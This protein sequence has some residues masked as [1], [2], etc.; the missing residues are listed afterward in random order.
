MPELLFYLILK[1]EFQINTTLERIA[2][3]GKILF[4]FCYCIINSKGI[5]ISICEVFTPD[6]D[7]HLTEINIT[8]RT[9]RKSTRLNSS[10]RSLSRMPSSA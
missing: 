8:M 5:V 10:H 2:T 7:A 6:T 9:D 1:V 3:L 4:L